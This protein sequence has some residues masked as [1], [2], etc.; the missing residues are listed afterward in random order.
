[1]THLSDK[2]PGMG[3]KKGHGPS[4]EKDQRREKRGT[5]VMSKKQIRAR[6]R[7]AGGVEKYKPTKQEESALMGKPLEK[8]DLEEL[9]R[10]R[11]KDKNGNFTGAKP[12]WITQAVHERAMDLFKDKIRGD[13]RSLTARGMDKLAELMES[14][15]VDDKGKP[16]VP[17]SVQAD[18]AKYMIE[19]LVGKPTQPIQQE[20]SIKLQGLLAGSLVQPE[21]V[22]RGDYVLSSSSATVDIIDVDEVD[23]GE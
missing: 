19:H 18:I 20:I 9:A 3:D 22:T 13:M 4:M 5:M 2:V 1:M 17:P 14:D 10:G 23:D 16:I 7:R 8:W 15:E 6:A 12:Q 11:P 21:E